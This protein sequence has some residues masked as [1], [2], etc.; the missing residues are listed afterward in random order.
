M[1]PHIGSILATPV[2]EHILW[3]GDIVAIVWMSACVLSGNDCVV[4]SLWLAIRM[5]SVC[6]SSLAAP[7]M[8]KKG[9]LRFVTLNSST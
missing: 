3:C 9:P 6:G 4:Q 5:V 8:T 2:W 7:Y 1:V